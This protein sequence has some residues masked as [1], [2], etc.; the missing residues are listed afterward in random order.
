MDLSH[1]I[2]IDIEIDPFADGVVVRGLDSTPD[3]IRVGVIRLRRW[4]VHP[5]D[6]AA[7]T[8]PGRSPYLIKVNYQLE[9]E[10]DLPPLR[11]FEF[12]LAL[13][14]TEPG[15]ATILDALPRA[16]S[17]PTPRTAHVISRHLD[18]VPTGDTATVDAFQ[19]ATTTAIV[20]HGIGSPEIRWRHAALEPA[21]IQPGS[22]VAWLVLLVNDTQVEQWFELT[23]RYDMDTDPDYT[24]FQRPTRFP[25]TLQPPRGMAHSPTLGEPAAAITPTTDTVVAIERVDDRPRVFI[26]YGHDD[27]A[28]KRAGRTLGR[29]LLAAGVDVHLDVWDEGRRRDWQHW[30]INQIT[31]ADFVVILASPVCRDVGDGTYRGTDHG[32]IRSELDIVRNL[33]HHHPQWQ[34]YLLPVVLPG[35]STDNLPLFLRPRTASHFLIKELTVAGVSELVAVMHE[36]QR[37]AW[38]LR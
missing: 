5:I 30:A 1:D 26:C 31:E 36:T 33:L 17:T 22:Y 13:V 18:L 14:E 21:G 8:F 15:Q 29:V 9:L 37:R 7:A 38:P 28:H 27:A 6:A 25:L 11:W 2:E 4:Q 32:G 12:D 19:P 24:P 23:A 10:P 3:R 16:A 35:E 20:V 34:D